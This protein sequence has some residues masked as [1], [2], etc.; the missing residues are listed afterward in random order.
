MGAFPFGRV[1]RS[2]LRRQLPG[3][4][5]RMEPPSLNLITSAV[6]VPRRESLF[7]IRRPLPIVGAAE[8]ELGEVRRRIVFVPRDAA[9][10]KLFHD[11][12]MQSQ[13]P[14]QAHRRQV[15]HGIRTAFMPL[16]HL[17]PSQCAGGVLPFRR[18]PY[19]RPGNRVRQLRV[20]QTA[21]PD[22]AGEVRIRQELA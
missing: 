7:R 18:F 17:P 2:W 11:P 14:P 22:A 20:P 13:Q 3:L 16:N 8:Q 6:P 15:V 12:R 9:T 5:A 19:P 21:G 4:V 10:P 1:G